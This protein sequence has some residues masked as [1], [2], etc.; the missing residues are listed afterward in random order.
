MKDCPED[1]DE[2]QTLCEIPKEG[3]DFSTFF[4]AVDTISSELPE[5]KLRD[6]GSTKKPTIYFYRNIVNTDNKTL[7]ADDGT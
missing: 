1:E 7:K 2:S 3:R 6:F 4:W 5:E